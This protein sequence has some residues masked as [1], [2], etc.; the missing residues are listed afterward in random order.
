[1]TKERAREKTA[2]A[3]HA[4]K[5]KTPPPPLTPADFVERYAPKIRQWFDG[6]AELDYS[7]INRAV[8][9]HDLRWP[10]KIRCRVLISDADVAKIRHGDPIP[11]EYEAIARAYLS[12]IV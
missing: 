8:M 6:A 11:E 10:S 9:I 7:W 4:Q 1:M 3:P 5:P 12:E 2:A